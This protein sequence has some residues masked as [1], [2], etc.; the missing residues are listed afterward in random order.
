MDD[1]KPTPAQL[2]EIEENKRPF[3]DRFKDMVDEAEQ[4]M[5]H[6]TTLP[7]T[8]VNG[9]KALHAEAT[10]GINRATRPITDRL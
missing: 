10:K 8:F 2:A 5:V 1:A 6:G 7:P 4:R 3:L 9:L